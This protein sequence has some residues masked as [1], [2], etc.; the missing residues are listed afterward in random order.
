MHIA[1][2]DVYV[3]KLDPVDPSATYLGRRNDGSQPHAD[4]GY[5]VRVPWRSLYS[6]RYETVLVKL[7]ASS[8]EIG[9]GEAL[10]PVG[11]EVLAEAITTLIAPQ[12]LGL[13]P[14]RL[15]PNWSALR[16][17]MRERGHLVG[18]QADALAAV[19]I[20]LWD[21]AGHIS[22]LS[23]ATL[24][25]G[26]FTDDVPVYISGLP[27][28]TNPERAEL[29][30]SWVAEGA[31]AVKL[32]I[33][34]GVAE[35]LEIYDAVAAAAPSLR[36]AVD[37]HWAYG[38]GE[39]LQL[40]RALDER[41]ALFLEAPL[42]PEDL[43][44]HAHL[45]GQLSTPVAIGET[46]R[47]RYEFSQWIAAGAVQ[48]VQPDIGR[49]GITEGMLIADL[50][51]TNHLV[52]APHHSIGLGISFAAGL[53]VAAS[54]EALLMFEYQP[55]TLKMASAILTEPLQRAAGQVPLTVGPGLG[56]HVDEE[57]VAAH[58]VHWAH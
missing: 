24:L 9:W 47:N 12:V 11:P 4:E 55:S 34:F 25:G 18:H 16:N 44:G 48:V 51:S 19:D 29:A 30:K 49:T 56:I 57:F 42:A 17:L 8:G 58:A 5:T 21:L 50:A 36:I 22:G 14:R 38:R 15:R 13:D 39:A 10:A 23:V 54:S 31:G 45:Q 28:T 37:A 52:V 32:H 3:L 1:K 53:H 41:H 26:A 46:L 43:R 6:A 35:D 27:V 20:A 2:V 40:G 7:T 33:G